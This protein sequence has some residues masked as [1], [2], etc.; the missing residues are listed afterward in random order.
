MKI[1]KL[2]ALVL[3]AACVL[4][5]VAGAQAQSFPKQLTFIISTGPGGGIDT[6]ARTL[7]AFLPRHLPGNPVIVVKNMPGA[8]GITATNYI[9]NSAPRD[10]SVIGLVHSSMIDLALFHPVKPEFDISKVTWIGNLGSNPSF[11]V[12]WHTSPIKTVD[13]MFKHEFLVGG[14]GAFSGSEV[15]PR[16]LNTLAG[17]KVKVISGYPNGNAIDLAM[18]REEI[19]GRCATSVATIQA[20]QSHWLRENKVRF[21]VLMGI[22][23][24]P[25]VPDVPAVTE[26]ISDPKGKKVVEALFGRRQMQR[27][28]LGPPNIPPQTTEILRRGFD[29]TVKD[30]DFI[31]EAK[32]R[33]I[34]LDTLTGEQCEELVKRI[35]ALPPD[36]IDAARQLFVAE[37]R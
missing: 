24:D 18:E 5:A 36:V 6:Y 37:E 11:C 26:I 8:G 21:L 22:N 17:T 12:S 33:G 2:C 20:T 16:V 30:P 10:G 35:Y 14:A 9:Y 19:H 4:C 13:D 29:A 25:N 15:N 27:P 7:T 31:A 32:R 3:V 1:S 23:R 34:E 28:V